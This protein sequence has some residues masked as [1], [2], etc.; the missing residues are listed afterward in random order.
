MKLYC[1]QGVIFVAFASQFQGFFHETFQP[2]S[3]GSLL[4]GEFVASVRVFSTFPPRSFFK[5][6]SITA[7]VHNKQKYFIAS[8]TSI[9]Y[10]AIRR[11]GKIEP[12][13]SFFCAETCFQLCVCVRF[14]SEYIRAIII[15]DDGCRK[16]RQK[17]SRRCSLYILVVASS[18][19]V[20]KSNN[21]HGHRYTVKESN[22]PSLTFGASK[23]STIMVSPQRGWW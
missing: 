16:I 5:Y 10:A 1:L 7:L 9:Q 2:W 6:S 3:H 13:L 18:P 8:R 21:D 12:I 23:P 11:K 17:A 22:S 15:T 14:C 20:V 19:F 4:H